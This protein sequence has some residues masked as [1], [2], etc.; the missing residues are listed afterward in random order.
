MPL[1]LCLVGDDEDSP[2]DFGYDAFEETCMDWEDD[3]RK[4]GM[5][6]GVNLLVVEDRFGLSGVFDGGGGAAVECVC[7]L[8]LDAVP[9]RL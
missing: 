9:G 4:N 1:E 2:D 7:V 5:A 3:R 8:A 6:L